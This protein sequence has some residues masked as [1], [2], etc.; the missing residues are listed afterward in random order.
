MT[1]RADDFDPKQ[2]V[3]N[4]GAGKLEPLQFARHT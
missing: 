2:P 3:M 1:G 4:A